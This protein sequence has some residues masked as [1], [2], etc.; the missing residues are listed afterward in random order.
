[1]RAQRLQ[2]SLEANITTGLGTFVPRLFLFM[3]KKYAVCLKP[4]RQT[5]K[6]MAVWFAYPDAPNQLWWLSA[7]KDDCQK[8]FGESYEFLCGRGHQQDMTNIQ[9]D[10]LLGKD[11]KATRTKA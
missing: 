8:F 4:M 2:S 9:V 1:M 11:P 10:K 6:F 3:A 7:L 5:D